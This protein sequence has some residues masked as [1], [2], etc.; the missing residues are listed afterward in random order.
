M[1]RLR[2]RKKEVVLSHAAIDAV[3][4][5]A[6]TVH[7]ALMNASVPVAARSAVA[8]ESP[9]AATANVKGES[10]NLGANPGRVVDA[11]AALV[12]RVVGTVIDT[13]AVGVELE[14]VMRGGRGAV[15]RLIL[16]VGIRRGG[17]RMVLLFFKE[18]IKSGG[19]ID[20][21]G[22]FS[23]CFVGCIAWC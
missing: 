1:R 12:T 14:V 17:G 8:I 9:A 20:R 18:R 19:V 21:E 13:G 6:V 4:A 16:Q 23:F 15:I 3:N 22:V 2:H 7:P 11:I 10:R 5:L